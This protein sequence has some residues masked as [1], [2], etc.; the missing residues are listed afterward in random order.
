MTAGSRMHLRM[1]CRV[2]PPDSVSVFCSAATSW[3]L[4]LNHSTVLLDQVNP[5]SAPTLNAWVRSWRFQLFAFPELACLI[6]ARHA[7]AFNT[8]GYSE[9]WLSLDCT[10]GRR[11]G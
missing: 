7:P 3:S 8:R 4:G 5:G 9:D 1:T 2:I 6:F 10:L 11:A